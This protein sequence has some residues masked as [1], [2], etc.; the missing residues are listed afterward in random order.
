MLNILEILRNLCY[1]IFGKVY[2]VGKE[3][4]KNMI[5]ALSLSSHIISRFDSNEQ[6]ITNLKLQKILYYVQGYFFK[7]FDKEA[8]SEE[9]Y[10]WQYGPVVPIAYY[11]YN[12]FGSKPLKVDREEMLVLTDK[13]NEL[14][15][16]IIVKCQD[17]PSSTLVN[18]T[19]NESPWKNTPSGHIITKQSIKKY[20]AF[21]DPLE[22]N[23]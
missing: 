6:K 21:N 16:K 5:N 17:I 12:L 9:I 20:F 2:K 14:I 18:K 1:N 8:F 11:E 19:H 13:E 10:C 15:E 4:D 22:I 23:T 7:T 3:V